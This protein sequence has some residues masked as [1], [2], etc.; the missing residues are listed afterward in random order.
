MVAEAQPVLIVYVG[1][2]L[3]FAI[4]LVLIVTLALV[5]KKQLQTELELA[6][7]HQKLSNCSCGDELPPHLPETA[8]TISQIHSHPPLRQ[9]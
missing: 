6:T 4:F 7:A 1:A 2:G 5:G 9:P 8:S 3:I